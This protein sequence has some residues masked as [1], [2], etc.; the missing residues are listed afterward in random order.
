MATGKNIIL[1]IAR[2]APLWHT[3]LI[4]HAIRKIGKEKLPQP[5]ISIKG[6]AID[7][8]ITPR[9]FCVGSSLIDQKLLSLGA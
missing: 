2:S 4:P 8:P 7:A 9:I 5:K 3:N 1:V 6:A